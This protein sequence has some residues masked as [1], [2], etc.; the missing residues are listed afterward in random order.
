MRIE[1]IRTKNV[2]Q[3]Y[4]CRRCENILIRFSRSTG[5]KP[6]CDVCGLRQMWKGDWI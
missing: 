6:N 1:G 4:H 3:M 5:F 2:W